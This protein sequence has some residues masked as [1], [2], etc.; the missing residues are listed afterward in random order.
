M[1]GHVSD[2]L[3]AYIDEPSRHASIVEPHLAGC[4]RCRAEYALVQVGMDALESLPLVEAPP[5]IWNSIETALDTPTKRPASVWWRLGFVAAVLVAGS[6]YWFVTR[7]SVRWEVDALSGAPVIAAKHI[8]QTGSIAAGEW[9]E[10]DARS[11][12]RIRIGD[13]GS[14]VLAP[15]TRARVVATRP[16]EHR[17]ALAHG[18]LHAQISAPPRLFFVDTASGTAMDLGC[19]YSLNTKEDGSGLLRVTRGWVSFDWNGRESLVPAGAICRIRPHAGPGTPYFED[20]SEGLKLA[21]DQF[22]DGPGINE[23]RMIFA[24]SRVRD[25]LTLWHLLSRVDATNRADVY[26]RIAALTPVPT[27][28]SRA[29]VLR[30][31]P[32]TLKH[33][34]DELAWTW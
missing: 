30:L 3:A 27:G 13:I 23:L 28:I 6:A 10:T 11:Q 24:E 22:D 4:E 20:A 1:S 26:D 16:R 25:T 15:N 32:E 29:Q 14:V 9:I 7:P 2:L 8:G 19:E 31:D 21:T 18:E 34:K 17:I 33:W 5:S 12:A